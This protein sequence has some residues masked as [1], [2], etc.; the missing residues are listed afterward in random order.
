MMSIDIDPWQVATAMGRGPLISIMCG[1]MTATCG[2]LIRDKLC[3]RRPNLLWAGRFHLDIG[4]SIDWRFTYVTA[5]LV[6]NLEDGNGRA[7]SR[8]TRTRPSTRARCMAPRLWRAR[9]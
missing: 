2:G 8:R 3:N 7:G 1:G 5:V 9:R 4:P 6:R